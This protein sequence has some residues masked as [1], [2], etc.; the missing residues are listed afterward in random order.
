L[1]KA[2]CG[3][4]EIPSKFLQRVSYESTA[5]L[6]DHRHTYSQAAVILVKRYKV[7]GHLEDLRNRVLRRVTAKFV[8]PIPSAEEGQPETGT[9]CHRLLQQVAE[10]DLGTGSCGRGRYP[11]WLAICIFAIILKGGQSY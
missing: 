8:V 4:F 5:T 9:K 11:I 3:K 10:Y 2:R 6:L 7:H 1:R